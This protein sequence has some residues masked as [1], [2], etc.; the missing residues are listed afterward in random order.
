MTTIIFPPNKF[1]CYLRQPKSASYSMTKWL[2]ELAK[3]NSC[4]YLTSMNYQQKNY[5]VDVELNT[6]ITHHMTANRLKEA[7]PQWWDRMEKIVTVRN[8]WNILPSKYY[9]M[10]K[11]G[12]SQVNTDNFENFC[13]SL[14]D[15]RGSLNPGKNYYSIDNKIVVEHIIPIE[16]L[17]YHLE[18]IFQGYKLPEIPF[19]NIGTVS[20]DTYKT[21]YVD[22][23][24]EQI[25]VDFKYE[26]DKFSYKF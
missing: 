20:Q 18:N 4:S 25:F 8:P 17:S 15:L 16:N 7:V 11:L 19:E 1:I 12:V 5:N 26:I 2:V 6:I 21:L 22:W 13:K 10:K 9:H 14:I 3:I 23:I 24:H